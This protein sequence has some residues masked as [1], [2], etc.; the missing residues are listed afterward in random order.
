[1]RNRVLIVDDNLVNLN[2]LAAMLQHEHDCVTAL[3]G[4]QALELLGA[5]PCPTSSCWT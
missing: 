3:S 5:P 2:I 4:A 1:M